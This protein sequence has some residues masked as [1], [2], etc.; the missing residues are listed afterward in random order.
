MGTNVDVPPQA[1]TPR[2]PPIDAAWN[3]GVWCRYTKWSAR[4]HAIAT[5]YMFSISARCSSSTPLGSPV[6]PPV[7]M[8]TTGSSS[9]GSSG[10]TGLPAVMRSSCVRSWGTSPAPMSTT[11]S[12]PVSFRTPSMSGAKKASTK[13]T[14]VSESSRMKASSL[15][16]RR[17][18]SGFTTPAPR[19]PAC[20][21]SRYS[22][23]LSAM[24][25]TR[26]PRPT[27]SSERRPSPSWS[28]RS[29]CSP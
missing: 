17:R 13:H 7:Y 16:A 21:S 15:G 18:L 28:T 3:I 5:W 10:T 19:K 20:Q 29:T 4:P 8:S 14:F 25:A 12:R 27:P 11:F 1:G 23:P 9:S 24:T 2:M 22:W 26:S 6:V